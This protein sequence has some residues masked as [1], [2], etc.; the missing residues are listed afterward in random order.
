MIQWFEAEDSQRLKK[1]VEQH[2]QA[3]DCFEGRNLINYPQAVAP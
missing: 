1:M 2:Q 3:R